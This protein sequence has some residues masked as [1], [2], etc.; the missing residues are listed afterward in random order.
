M[1]N[2]V[3]KYLEDVLCYADLA[4]ND[5]RSVRAELA[6]HLQTI[7]GAAQTQNPREIYSMLKDQ[8]G[9]PKAVGRGIAIAKGRIRTFLKKQRR[10]LPWQIAIAL[11]L[12][13]AVRYSIAQAFYVTGD[14]VSPLIPRGARVLVYK[15]AH[16]FT[17][18]DIIVYRIA[19]GE[20]RLGKVLHE[21]P[22]GNWI[23]ER[24]TGK[25]RV[26]SELPSDQIIGRV[27]LNTR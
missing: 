16:T 18:G 21:T 27:F 10:K 2:P 4:G 7:A 12:A 20:N 17:P 11:L 14:G 23:V 25:D 3:E 22:A 9:T 1:R 26:E 24:N 5:E 6:D 19:N 15:L 8:F 13:F